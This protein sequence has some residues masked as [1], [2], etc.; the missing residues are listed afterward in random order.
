MKNLFSLIAQANSM[1]FKLLGVVGHNEEKKEKI[2]NILAND[3]WILIDVEKELIELR[4]KIERS[5]SDQDLDI[6]LS[7]KIKEWFHSKPDKLILSNASI[8]YHEAFMKTSPIGAFKYNSRNKSCIIFLEDV[9]F[10]VKLTQF[11][12]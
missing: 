3:G 4:E 5:L 11:F 2:I 1:R 6:E 10:H 12:H 9:N 8:L 7:S